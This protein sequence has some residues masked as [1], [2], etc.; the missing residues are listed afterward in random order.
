M[1][2]L[3]VRAG[4]PVAWLRATASTVRVPASASPWVE[5]AR[6]LSWTTWT[7]RTTWKVPTGGSKGASRKLAIRLHDDGGALPPTGGTHRLRPARRLLRTNNATAGEN[8]RSRTDFPACARMSRGSGFAS[9]SRSRLQG[10]SRRRARPGNDPAPPTFWEADPQR[11]ASMRGAV[12]EA[13]VVPRRRRAPPTL[14]GLEGYLLTG[15]AEASASRRPEGCR[16]AATPAPDMHVS[17]WGTSD[18]RPP[19]DRAH[20]HVPLVSCR[21]RPVRG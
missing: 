17:V 21:L 16:K 18:D 19:G 9:R 7:P 10:W 4:S 14:L 1:A 6:Q 8:R 5:G 3:S 2:S 15:P 13:R 12:V 11:G 20:G